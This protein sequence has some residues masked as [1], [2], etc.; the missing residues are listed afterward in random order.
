M[1][2]EHRRTQNWGR[3]GASATVQRPTNE[4]DWS[5]IQPVHPHHVSIYRQVFIVQH[6]RVG[7]EALSNTRQSVFICVRVCRWYRP[8]HN[9]Y[10]RAWD[11]CSKTAML[12][13]QQANWG[14]YKAW[15]R[16]TNHSRAINNIEMSTTQQ[17]PS[18]LLPS[19]HRAVVQARPL[20]QMSN[21]TSTVT[22][23]KSGP[24]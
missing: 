10:S 13:E 3:D 20:L 23:D 2:S 15:I 9:M 1:D 21:V 11:V 19:S 22:V 8:M 24:H 18:S 14:Q 12:L 6:S 4:T 5:V 7:L 17:Q 16:C